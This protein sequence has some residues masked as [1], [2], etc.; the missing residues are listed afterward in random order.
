[1]QASESVLDDQLPIADIVP[2][3]KELTVW[4]GQWSRKWQQYSISSMRKKST[5]NYGDTEEKLQG[6]NNPRSKPRAMF[7]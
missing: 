2:A 1:M 5:G 6:S 3:F 4:W 7:P